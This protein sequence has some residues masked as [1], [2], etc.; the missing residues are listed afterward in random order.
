MTDNLNVIV[1]A[2]DYVTIYDTLDYG[3]SE[4]I[5]SAIA[6][7]GWLVYSDFKLVGLIEYLTKNTN[8]IGKKESK[9][10]EEKRNNV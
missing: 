1:F 3:S 9:T 10:I 2:N 5:F 8:Y 7:D 4:H 6:C